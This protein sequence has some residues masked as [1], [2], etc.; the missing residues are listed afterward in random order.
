MRA[1]YAFMRTLEKYTIP[2]YIIASSSDDNIFNTSYKKNVL[3]TRKH[4]ELD[5]NDIIKS[6]K[7]V[8]KKVQ[9]ENFLIAPSTEALNRFLLEYRP[10]FNELNCVIPLVNKKL[11]EK[12]SDKYSFGKLCEKYDIK[13]PGEFLVDSIEVPCVAKPKRYISQASNQILKPILIIEQYQLEDFLKTYEIE[14]FYFQEFLG[15]QSFYLLYYFYQDGTFMKYSQE[16]L[17]QQSEG[18]SILA[19]KNSDFHLKY[20][21]EPYE[22]LFKSINFRGLVMIEVKLTHKG[23]YMIEANPRFWGPSQLFV[24]AGINFFDAL[25]YDYGIISKKPEQ[26]DSDRVIHYFW[27][28]GKSFEEKNIKNT[29][30]HNYSREMLFNEYTDWNKSNILKRKDTLEIHKKL[31]QE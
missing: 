23:A 25:L 7:I 14:D 21:S 5:L 18:R 27:D 26:I 22:N 1:L 17:I 13:T 11:Y 9:E 2:Y 20:Y 30:F 8:Q 12:I 31:I 29:A 24:D 3:V 10:L 6:V 19:A 16:N 28:D 15:G 4:R